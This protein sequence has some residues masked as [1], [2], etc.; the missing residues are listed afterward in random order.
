[1]N[2]TV[3]HVENLGKRYRVG[4]T[5]GYSTLRDTLA[6]IFTTPFRKTKSGKATAKHE[7]PGKYIW[8]LKNI[9]FEVKRGEALGIIGGNGAGKTTLLR[10][11]TRIAEP[12]EGYAEIR[13]RVGSLLEVGTGFHPELTG[14]ENVFLNG[15]ILGMKN[16]EIKRKFDEIVDFSG[17]KQFIDTPLKRYSTG[18]QV[19]LAFAVAAFMEPE[20]L[21][22]DEVLAVG[23]AQFQ[24][25]CLGKMGELAGEGRTV[26]F[27][28]H[29]MQA[30]TRLCSSAVLLEKGQVTQTGNAAEVVN[31]YLNLGIDIPGAREW[32]EL[33][34]AP[35]DHVVRLRSVC[36]CNDEG[37]IADIIDIRRTFYLEM[38]YDVLKSEAV[39]TPVFRLENEDGIV[40]FS[41]IDSDSKWRS[42]QRAAGHY[43]TRVQIPGNLLSEGRITVLAGISTISPTIKHVY[44]KDVISFQ[45]I[46]STK[47]DSARGDWGGTIPG[48]IRPLLNWTT[49]FKEKK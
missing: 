44:E 31:Y 22:V 19:R 9:S 47:G 8:A 2:D 18:M 25:K 37:K 40:V 21:L 12:T 10:I 27:V 36:T 38:Q 5:T 16:R 14:R 29:N 15:A 34:S 26:L 45:V 43:T 3:I 4:Q 39:L 1:M 33:D 49:D 17:V 32:K 24:K 20:I 41:T 28:S 6:N 48:V 7:M 11:L 30:I 23:D 13:G 46:D 42:E 35:G